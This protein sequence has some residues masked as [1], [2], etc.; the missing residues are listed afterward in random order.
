MLDF[1]SLFRSHGTWKV[2]SSKVIPKYLS[3]ISVFIIDLHR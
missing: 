3:R 2:V 1:F